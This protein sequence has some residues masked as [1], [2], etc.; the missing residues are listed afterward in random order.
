MVSHT[1][2][3]AKLRWST[4]RRIEKLQRTSRLL[5]LTNNGDTFRAVP[6]GIPTTVDSS[7]WTSY[8]AGRS[9]HQERTEPASRAETRPANT[10]TNHRRS[11]LNSNHFFV[12][13]T[14]TSTTAVLLE[15]DEQSYDCCCGP[16]EQH[17]ITEIP[18][19]KS[20]GE[21]DELL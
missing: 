20:Y 11:L 3:N 12:A 17:L 5:F 4:V 19:D 16:R 15:Q 9:P 8:L 18:G 2:L 14:S 10:S 7:V 1:S 13:V 21:E 6:G